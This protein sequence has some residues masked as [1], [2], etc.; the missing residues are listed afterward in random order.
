[1][2]KLVLSICSLVLSIVCLIICILNLIFFDNANLYIAII[3]INTT[4]LVI[5]IFISIIGGNK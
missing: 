3:I 5:D 4:T 2:K 1:M